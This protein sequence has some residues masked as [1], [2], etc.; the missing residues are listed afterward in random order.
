MAPSNPA[1]DADVIAALVYQRFRPQ[2]EKMKVVKIVFPEE[3]WYPD[4][5]ADQKCDEETVVMETEVPNEHVEAVHDRLQAENA[6]T[7]SCSPGDKV[8]GNTSES[9]QQPTLFRRL[10]SIFSSKR[11]R[12][13]PSDTNAEVHQNSCKDHPDINTE[14]DGVSEAKKPRTESRLQRIWSSVKKRMSH[15]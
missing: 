9:R 13:N 10:S 4:K 5:D 11:K 7:E 3:Y 1:V 12:K 14:D 2:C 8:G 6:V 15:H